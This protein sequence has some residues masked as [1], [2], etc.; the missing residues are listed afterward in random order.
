[1]QN[2]RRESRHVLYV[3]IDII[4]KWIYLQMEVFD[5]CRNVDMEVIST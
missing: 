2:A 1:M 3:D 4:D 5:G